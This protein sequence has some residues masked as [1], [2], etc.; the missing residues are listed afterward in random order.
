MNE[1]LSKL[2]RYP[3]FSLITVSLLLGATV[4]C[5]GQPPEKTPEEIEKNRLEHI[6]R[7]QRE[8]EDA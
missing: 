8:M 3:A 1:F 5:G 7:S 6:E 2:F 4:G